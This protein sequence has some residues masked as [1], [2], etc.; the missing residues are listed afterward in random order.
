[1]NKVILSAAA[2]LVLATGAAFADNTKAFFHK[3]DD[4]WTV[5]GIADGDLTYC[6]AST[7]WGN[8]SY[9]IFY[10]T[11]KDVANVIVHNETWNIQDP[12]G[13]FKGYSATFSF[14]GN[15]DPYQAVGDYKLIDPQTI[16][17]PDVNDKFYVNWIKYDVLTIV[18]PGDISKID[19]DL[20]GTKEAINDMGDC[21]SKF[22]KN[23][24]SL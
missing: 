12:V 13:H 4:Q 23:S 24:N 6:S 10:V 22:K 17:I 20:H 18:M 3:D 21:L 8:D 19:I 2:A 7:K 16:G 9:F 5:E 1:M 14:F 15:S 11:D